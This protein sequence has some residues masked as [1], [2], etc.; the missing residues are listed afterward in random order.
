MLDIN[1][2][3]SSL[4][5]SAVAYFFCLNLPTAFLQPG[6][7]S[8]GDPCTTPNHPVEVASSDMRE[9]G[10]GLDYNLPP[11]S[12]PS[13][14]LL[15]PFTTTMNQGIGKIM[16]PTSRSATEQGCAH[17][18]TH[19]QDRTSKRA[20]AGRTELSNFFFAFLNP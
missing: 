8:F 14:L 17:I 11:S 10:S 20:R 1:W 16:P 5:L 4:S 18:G 9:G 3:G 12:P 19:R 2:M 13:L 15:L 6:K 7:H